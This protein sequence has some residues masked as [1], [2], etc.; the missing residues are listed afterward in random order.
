MLRFI[1][2]YNFTKYTSAAEWLM[3]MFL[4]NSRNAAFIEG[5]R[6]QTQSVEDRQQMVCKAARKNSSNWSLDTA[7]VTSVCLYTPDHHGKTDSSNCSLYKE[8]VAAIGLCFLDQPTARL[9]PEAHVTSRHSEPM[10]A[11][12]LLQRANVSPLLGLKQSL[13][14]WDCK[15]KQIKIPNQMMKNK[16]DRSRWTHT[17][18]WANVGL[19]L[20]QRRSRWFNVKPTLVQRLV[21]EPAYCDPHGMFTLLTTLSW[22][23][24]LITWTLKHLHADD[25][26]MILKASWRFYWIQLYSAQRTHGVSSTLIQTLEPIGNINSLTILTDYFIN[27]DN[28]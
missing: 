27:H 7:C 17:R 23:L 25:E 14:K 19:I 4:A 21:W 3:V 16:L 24:P 5:N 26:M 20:G 9:D 1:W 22:F 12:R 8:A 15:T 11:Y 28:Q 13:C 6:W 2:H 10:L 18:R